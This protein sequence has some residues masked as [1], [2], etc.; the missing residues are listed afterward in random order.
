MVIDL[1]EFKFGDA[2]CPMAFHE[3]ILSVYQQRYQQFRIYSYIDSEN[4]SLLISKDN[5]DLTQKE[6]QIKD[7]AYQSLEKFREYVVR[8]R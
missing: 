5:K 2:S 3:K 8:F 4:K 7:R 6:M 1:M